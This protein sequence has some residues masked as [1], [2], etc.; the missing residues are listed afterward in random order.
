MIS[1][2]FEELYKQLNL[3]QKDAVDSIEGPVM[4]IAG[5]GTGKT[6]I[7]T[8]RIANILKNT[9]TNP[10]NILALTFTESGASSM[11]KRL[12]EI[13]GSAA[14]SAGISTFHGFCNG[15]IKNYPENFPHII[16]SQNIT[17]V[18]QI[19]IL[20]DL[21]SNLKLKELKPFGDTFYYLRHILSDINTLKR[22]GVDEN[23]FAEIVKKEEKSFELIEDLYHDKGAHKGKMK[24][25]YKL[26]QKRIEKN[27]ELAVIYSEYQ[28]KMRKNKFYDYS[29]MIMEV[30]RILSADEDLLLI[31]QEQYQ[32]ILV[33]EH[34]DTNNAQNK[35]LELL[36][37]FHQNPNIFIV[38][39]EKQAIFRFQGASLQNF[40]YFKNIYPEAK[41]I[42]LEENY[43]STQAI[44]DSAHSLI[45]GPKQLKAHSKYSEIPNTIYAFS[46]PE[47]EYYFL[48][49]DIEEKIKQGIAP[50]EIAVLFRDNKDS[51]LVVEMFRRFGISFSLESDQDVLSDNDIKKLILLFRAINGFGSQDLFIECLHIDFLNFVPLDIYKIIEYGN[52]NKISVFEIVRS[53][54]IL[55][56][57]NLEN[58]G[59]IND[60]F[61]K[62]SSWS[63]FAKNKNVA[64]F[65]EIVA[66]ESGY[67]A[68]ILS[69]KN[70]VEKMERLTGFF[71]ETEAFNNS[72]K[73]ALLKDFI[74][75][76]NT[77]KEHNILIKKNIISHIG[78]RARL[79]TA[80]KSKGMEFEYVYIINAFD[81][82]WGN[83]RRA[84]ILPLPKQIYS[85]ISKDLAEG[86]ENSDER[87]LFYV[88]LTRARKA[89]V[90]TYAKR[91]L[92]GRDQLPSQFL[93]E[94]KPELIQNGDAEKYEKEFESQKEI[95][96]APKK[97]LPVNV[98]DKDFIKEIFNRNGLSVTALNN[99]LECPWNYFYTNLLRIPKAPTKYQFY[100][101]A[102]HE[103]LKSCFNALKQG[104]DF[105]KEFLINKFVEILDKQAINRNEYEEMKEK[106]IKDLAGYFNAFS[107]GWHKNIINE[108][109]V[110][111]VILENV[112]LTGKIDKI[113]ILN[114]ST[115]SLAG[116]A[117]QADKNEVNV[118]DYKTSK[119]KSK[120]EIE[121]NTKNSDGNIKRQLVFYNLLLNEYQNKKYKMLSGEIDF[122]SPNDKG[123][124]KKEIFS[125]SEKEVA[126]LKDLIKKVADEILNLS[127]WDK[128][129]D[130][131]DCEFC[132]LRNFMK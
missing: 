42:A 109:N 81:G 80:H 125:I 23:K 102:V 96:F 16:G 111:G 79:M 59:Q 18:D 55:N 121:G 68:Y 47:V 126:E 31:L 52:R 106:G 48:A 87:R 40:L 46:R 19:K 65:F 58:S 37:N 101:I 61:K 91:N 36:C 60:F 8:L 123:E 44:L 25:E 84:D 53:M 127:F 93:Q 120:N 76:L 11:R 22:E 39:D 20:E 128:R 57:L 92:E 6:Q 104:N 49:K 14:Y 99:Y 38:G 88:A 30:Q 100:G 90:I 3:Q 82:H 83:K 130:K 26:L 114:P 71:D 43:R 24:G 116:Q 95:I 50:E 94:M 9:D 69:G 112:R 63:V 51:F 17:E 15:V 131:K 13:V 64:E 45:S 33:D 74:D 72:H 21:I 115:G 54:E 4:V 1:A 107:L 132:Q 10:E 122:I 77:L 78:K 66:R 85:L 56:S 117:G 75:Y 32:Y 124:Y 34:Q 108:L 28:E 41:L 7:L 105:G 27:K 2:K 67:L 110:V 73:E 118:I 98:K 70:S 129:C 113:E 35:I 89:V 12:T 86:D 119:P 29:D 62:L 97:D 103:T 5:P